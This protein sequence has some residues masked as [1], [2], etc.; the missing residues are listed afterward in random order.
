[1]ADINRFLPQYA[2]TSGLLEPEYDQYDFSEESTGAPKRVWYHDLKGDIDKDKSHF[3]MKK[4]DKSQHV[5]YMKQNHETGEMESKNKYHAVYKY[6][7]G[8][9][10]LDIPKMKQW[11]QK[12]TAAKQK[13]LE[14]K[15]V[16][17]VFNA[18]K[19]AIQKEELKPKHS[20]HKGGKGADACQ[21]KR[22]VARALRDAAHA[23]NKECNEMPKNKKPH[24]QHAQPMPHK[25]QEVPQW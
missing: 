10:R 12:L 24:E 7:K 15:P 13:E 11:V 22:M 25:S 21:I 1:M 16:L 4:D 17:D 9:E 19:A 3:I 23:L 2:R 20:K 8:A 6:D 18:N 14:T 5:T